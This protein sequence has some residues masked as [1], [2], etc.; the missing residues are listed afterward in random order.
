MFLTENGEW[1]SELARA[2]SWPDL[3]TMHDWCLRY[4]LREVDMVLMF[5]NDAQ[6]DCVFHL[7]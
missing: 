1:T 2:K 3:V 4:G 7:T 6:H 5:D